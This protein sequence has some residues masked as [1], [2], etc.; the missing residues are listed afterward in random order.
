MVVASG[1]SPSPF[2]K[3][4]SRMKRTNEGPA[5]WEESM[6]KAQQLLRNE[7]VHY[8]PDSTLYILFPPHW[9]LTRSP[10]RPRTH[11]VIECASLRW[12]GHHL[13]SPGLERSPEPA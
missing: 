6:R 2:A 10:A 12:S 4:A 8:L 9:S 13:T 5:P 3:K 1:P 11:A 7:Q